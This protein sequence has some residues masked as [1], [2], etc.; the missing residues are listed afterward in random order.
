MSKRIETHRVWKLTFAALAA[1]ALSGLGPAFAQAARTCTH[2]GKTY[3]AGAKLTIE[4]KEMICD[5]ASG[6]WV[7]ASK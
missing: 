3:Q 4:G 7:A 2:E 5:G 1:L 6:T